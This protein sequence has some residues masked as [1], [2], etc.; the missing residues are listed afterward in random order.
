MDAKRR[1]QGVPHA[2]WFTLINVPHPPGGSGKNPFS[3]PVRLIENS[4]SISFVSRAFLFYSDATASTCGLFE[5]G[6]WTCF[7]AC[8]ECKVRS[9]S[10][11]RIEFVVVRGLYRRQRTRIL[12]LTIMVRIVSYCSQLTIDK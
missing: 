3:F 5:R 10:S 11:K 6:S 12:S 9:G 4:V 1:T 8:E 7:F 2:S